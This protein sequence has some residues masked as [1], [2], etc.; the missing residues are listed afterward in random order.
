MYR[1]TDKAYSLDS[2]SKEILIN[3]LSKERESRYQK[4]RFMER[5]LLLL[6]LMRSE[7]TDDLQLCAEEYDKLSG[8]AYN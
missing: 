2:K 8:E 6:C 7:T 1:K 3:L 4:Y 5:W